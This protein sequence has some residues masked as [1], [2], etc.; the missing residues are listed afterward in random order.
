VE[1]R[2]TGERPP[3]DVLAQAEVGEKE[4][5]ATHPE[6][7]PAYMAEAVL[8]F[9]EQVERIA[10][11]AVVVILGALLATVTVGWQAVWFVSL[12]LVV[13]RPVA[14]L[15]G[16]SGSLT[17]WRQRGLMGW[18]G[19]RGIGSLYYLMYAVNHGLSE[20]L[21]RQL[22]DLTLVTV[23]VSIVVHGVSVTP[24]MDVYTRRQ[25]GG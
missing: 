20:N 9:S 12:L 16:L 18:F 5:L 13:V 25:Q 4:T 7:A 1:M 10:E 11:V 15:V 19:I 24:L 6:A 23:A 17:S 22:A 3:A 8:G 21:A 14:V 2:A